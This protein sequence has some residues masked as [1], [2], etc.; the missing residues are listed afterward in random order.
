MFRHKETYRALEIESDGQIF[1][2]G[3]FFE[4]VFS[5]KGWQNKSP[6]LYT[7]SKMLGSYQLYNGFTYI[8]MHM[9]C[10]KHQMHLNTSPTS[11]ERPGGQKIRK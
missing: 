1:V 7:K 6:K 4:N 8:H 9:R 2:L 5:L 3:A 11:F 10:K